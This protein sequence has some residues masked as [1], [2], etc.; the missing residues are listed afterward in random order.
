M[1]EALHCHN[2][3]DF[4]NLFAAILKYPKKL[5]RR[6]HINRLKQHTVKYY[7]KRFSAHT[8]VE[9]G[10]YKGDMVKAVKKTFEKI[11]SI[12]LDEQLYKRAERMFRRYKHITIIRGDSSEIL[13][14]TADIFW[15]DAHY[16]GRMTAKSFPIMRELKRINNFSVILIDDARKYMKNEY[17]NIE[18]LKEFI[19]RKWPN[20]K[21]EVKDDIIR[22]TN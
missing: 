10:T 9:S 16:S 1:N 21:F 5:L 6:R 8:F 2:F 4:L 20:S 18:D 13:P 17:G 15:L 3:K 22:I 12:E 7:A 19:S 11:Y 14:K